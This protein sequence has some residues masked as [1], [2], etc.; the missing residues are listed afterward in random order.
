MTIES[1]YNVTDV[2]DISSISTSVGGDFH[3]EN[4]E[5]MLTTQHKVLRSRVQIKTC[6]KSS[7]MFRNYT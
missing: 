2:F 7:N 3:I 1:N 5:E 6:L 4:S